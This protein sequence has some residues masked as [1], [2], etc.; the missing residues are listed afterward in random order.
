[1]YA[2]RNFV[3]SVFRDVGLP[4]VLVLDC[5][6]RL[7][8]AF[9]TGLP[10][11]LGAT[12]IF[13]LQLHHNTTSKDCKVERVNGVI[14]DVLCSFDSERANDWPA[15]VPLVEFAINDSASPLGS[16]P[17]GLHALLRRL[18]PAP[19]PPADTCRLARP[20]N[21]SGVWRGCSAPDGA[22]DGGGAGAAAGAA[23]PAQGGARHVQA[24]RAVCGDE[25][26]LDMEHTPL[27]SRSLLSPRWTG[28]A[29]SRS[30]H[31]RRPAHTASTSTSLRRGAFSQSSTS[32]SS[33]CAALGGD[34]DVGPPPPVSGADGAPEHQVQEL[35]KF[36]M[37]YGWPYVLMR[38]AGLD[39]DAAGD[40]DNLTN[41]EPAIRVP[42]TLPGP[43]RLRT[44]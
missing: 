42:A 16:A 22:R 25:V 1:M 20:G 3:A 9:W 30:S 44:G 21:A 32:T 43:S 27:P 40:I 28:R 19:P 37:R 11:A 39:C 31:A 17:V 26:L 6:M 24:R 36:K 23:G 29:P 12:L 41:C 18:R 14:V 34:S 33:A 15:L 35:L 10:D 4:D 13:G 5:N 38:W 7:T 2:A 8:S